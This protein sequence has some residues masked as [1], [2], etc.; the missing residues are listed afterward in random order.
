MLRKGHTP[1]F[2]VLTDFHQQ[3]TFPAQGD[4]IAAHK[5]QL[6][7]TLRPRGTFLPDSVP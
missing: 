3:A 6:P 2:S 1:G 5:W 7:N 4:S